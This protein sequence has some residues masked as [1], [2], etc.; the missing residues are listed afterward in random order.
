MQICYD[1]NC[2][3]NGYGEEC[4]E[5]SNSSYVRGLNIFRNGMEGGMNSA[6]N[7]HIVVQISFH[8]LHFHSSQP[9]TTLVLNCCCVTISQLVTRC[10]CLMN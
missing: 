3:D 9:N 8:S 10:L 4:E 5:W 1:R 7:L 6:N 2:E